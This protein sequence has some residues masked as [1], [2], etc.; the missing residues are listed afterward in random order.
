MLS[1][2]GRALV[3]G[4]IK[5]SLNAFAPFARP[6]LHDCKDD[7][8]S[9]SCPFNCRS[10]TS[11][12]PEKQS[13]ELPTFHGKNLLSLVSRARDSHPLDWSEGAGIAEETDLLDLKDP[14]YDL[15][16]AKLTKLFSRF[17]P[18]RRYLFHSTQ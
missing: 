9:I 3:R 16:S 2:R 11:L 10:L 12:T 5:V 6:F 4:H 7:W 14:H 18:N 15:T 13:P 17:K 1:F 8:P